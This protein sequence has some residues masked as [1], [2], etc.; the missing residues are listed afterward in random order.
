MTT[1]NWNSRFL[2]MI[3][4]ESFSSVQQHLY[5]NKVEGNLQ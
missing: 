2:M 4:I 5:L 3:I 1:F